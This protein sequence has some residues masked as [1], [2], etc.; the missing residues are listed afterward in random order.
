MHARLPASSWWHRPVPSPS[1]GLKRIASS[2]HSESAV[3]SSHSPSRRRHVPLPELPT[4]ASR[5]SQRQ[6]WPPRKHR[7]CGSIR[8]HSTSLLQ[9]S[10]RTQVPVVSS[11]TKPPGRQ[12]WS[13]RQRPLPP[14]DPASVGPP[15]ANPPANPPPTVLPPLPPPLEPP[16]AIPAPTPKF[17]WQAPATQVDVMPQLTHAAPRWP[18]A[19][20]VVPAAQSPFVSQ[21]PSGHVWPSHTGRM[22]QPLA[23]RRHARSAVATKR[24]RMF[25][26]SAT[27]ANRSPASNRRDDRASHFI[28]SVTP[29]TPRS[30]ARSAVRAGRAARPAS[31]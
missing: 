2:P 17:C 20:E 12:S 30:N 27:R 5:R 10:P 25:R 23:S 14:P 29:A 16:P 3:H 15:P 26:E 22:L 31:A 4:G 13:R 21:Q 24:G 7:S 18:Q 19:D 9:P 28:P 8:W 11:Q 1:G 6:P